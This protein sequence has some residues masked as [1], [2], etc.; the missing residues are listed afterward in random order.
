MHSTKRN[1]IPWILIIRI[2]ILLFLAFSF[3]SIISGC[4]KN[5]MSTNTTSGTTGANEILIKGMAFSPASKTITAG[6]TIKWTNQD[7]INHTVTS[8]TPGS[9]S[10]LFDSGNIAPDGTFSYTFNQAG[11]FS[12]YCKI[13]S[14]MTGTITVQV[15]NTGGGGGY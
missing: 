14:S 4:S 15:A 12:F 2:P 13:H 5:D 8:G 11:T 3:I 10:G 6:T 7:N 1:L 9:P